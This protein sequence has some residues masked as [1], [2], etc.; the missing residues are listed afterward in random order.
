MSNTNN[1]KIRNYIFLIIGSIL[2]S[3]IV[4]AV[5]EEIVS[6]EGV[7]TIPREKHHAPSGGDGREDGELADD[8]IEFDPRL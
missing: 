4:F 1:K 5:N 8:S 7:E 3:G 2:F 6:G